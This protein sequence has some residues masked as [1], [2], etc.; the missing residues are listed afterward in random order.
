MLCV[1]VA[2]ALVG[3]GTLGYLAYKNIDMSELGYIVFHSKYLIS[4]TIRVTK[5]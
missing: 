2:M 4:S 5:Y 1:V 3:L